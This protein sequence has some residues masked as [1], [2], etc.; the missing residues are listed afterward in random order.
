M[1]SRGNTSSLGRII[2]HVAAFTVG[3]RRIA[4]IVQSRP[5]PDFPHLARV[6]NPILALQVFT[7]PL[8]FSRHP[9]FP[10]DAFPLNRASPLPPW[11]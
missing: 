7:F 8:H 11:S 6:I 2:F 4:I 5:F 9:S 10:K 1:P 3:S